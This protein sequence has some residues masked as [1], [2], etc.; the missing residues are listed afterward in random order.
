MQ[1][2]RAIGV[3]APCREPVGGREHG[4]LDLDRL[5]AA[6]VA[7]HRGLV[8]RARP[9]HEEP[10]AP[11]GRERPR[12]GSRDRP[13]QV[14]E[15]P[16]GLVPRDS[17]VLRATPTEACRPRVVLRDAGG[18]AGRQQRVRRAEEG[19]GGLAELAV[20]AERGVVV[21]DRH[22]PLRHDVA[23]V[24]LGLHVV[25][26]H[27]GLP[28]AV[29]QHPVDRTP[30]PVARQKRA[31]QIERSPPRQTEHF[32]PDDLAEVEGEEKVGCQARD[33]RD[34][35]G[36]IHGRRS[37]NGQ[38]RLPGALGDRAE[39]DVLVCR[40]GMRYDQCDLGAERQELVETDVPDVLVSH[41]DDAHGSSGSAG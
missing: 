2:D 1:L 8:Q 36:R 21:G 20:Q 40:V 3:L 41:H 26:R 5:A 25:E 6:Q 29:D 24:G 12:I 22:G 39:P 11:V 7:V 18:G 17:A 35:V 34:H 38:A 30:T 31:M 9:P 4:H 32:G 14:V 13:D 37:E 16:G 28:L 23:P 27:P 10:L 19:A 33:R 15:S